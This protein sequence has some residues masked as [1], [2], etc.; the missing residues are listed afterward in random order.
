M[1]DIKIC[2][3]CKKPINNRRSI[4]GLKASYYRLGVEVLKELQYYPG[5]FR[6]DQQ[7]DTDLCESCTKLLAEFLDGKAVEAVNNG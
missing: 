6:H 7:I 4:L 3:R 5:E 1:A 2:D